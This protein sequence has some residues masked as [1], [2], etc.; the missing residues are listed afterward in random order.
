MTTPPIYSYQ[1]QAPV[2]S[3]NSGLSYQTLPTVPLQ[4][5]PP[6]AP[7]TTAV[8]GPQPIPDGSGSLAFTGADVAGTVVFALVL[9]SVGLIVRFFGRNPKATKATYVPKHSR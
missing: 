1:V 8:V 5:Q 4:V 2:Y 6:S 3:F 7:P 9:I